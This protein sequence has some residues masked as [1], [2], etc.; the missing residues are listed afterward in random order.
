MGDVVV[1][2]CEAVTLHQI[3]EF[4]HTFDAKTAHEVKMLSRAG[5]GL[6]GGR[7][8]SHIVAR[9]VASETG[10]EAASDGP[11]RSRP[12]V[13]PTMLRQVADPEEDA[14][15]GLSHHVTDFLS[16]PQAGE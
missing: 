14:L 15:L 10:N 13:R 4:I 2:R 16:H 6:C 5:M 11:P 8:C 9:I 1:C 12:P 3:Q 7:T